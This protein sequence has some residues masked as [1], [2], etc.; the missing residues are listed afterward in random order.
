MAFGQSDLLQSTASPAAAS[1]IAARARVAPQRRGLAW[2]FG[3][4]AGPLVILS[5]LAALG[6]AVGRATESLAVGI[7]AADLVF[8]LAVAA[9]S[10]LFLGNRR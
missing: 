2:A 4:T 7:M 10:T 9:W 5:M 3:R 1:A 6:M 8:L